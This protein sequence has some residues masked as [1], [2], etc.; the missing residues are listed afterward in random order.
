MEFN[1]IVKNLLLKDQKKS[2]KV[3]EFYKDSIS[4]GDNFIPL[5]EE[6]KDP[7]A[8][9]LKAQ[10]DHLVLKLNNKPNSLATIDEALR[11]QILVEEI[12]SKT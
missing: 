2:R 11:V 1:L 5:R 10:L 4:T 6:P 12:L 8:V 9:S 7:R 3:A